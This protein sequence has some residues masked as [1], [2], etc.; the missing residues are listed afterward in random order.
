[1]SE[2]TKSDT[3]EPIQL[4]QIY[5]NEITKRL[6]IKL[7]GTDFVSLIK[8]VVNNLDNTDYQTTISNNRY[9]IKIQNNFC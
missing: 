3:E 1:M 6:W 7:S 8:G 5:L 2:R 9:D 4:K